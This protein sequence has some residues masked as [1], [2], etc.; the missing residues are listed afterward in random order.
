LVPGL[1]DQLESILDLLFLGQLDL[2]EAV[3]RLENTAN[4]LIEAN[5]P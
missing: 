5:Q 1:S 2:D 3:V 4:E